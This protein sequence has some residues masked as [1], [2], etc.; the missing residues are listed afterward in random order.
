MEQ[1]QEKAV[2]RNYRDLIVW[3]QGIQFAKA[4][5]VLIQ[6]FPKQEMLALS[7]QIRRAAVSARRT[8]PKDRRAGRQRNFVDSFTSP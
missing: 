8:L 7:D 3:Q 2:T 6:K 5:Y 1:P 4:V